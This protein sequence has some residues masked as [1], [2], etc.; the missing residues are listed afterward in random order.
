MRNIHML[1]SPPYFLFTSL[2]L[3]VVATFNDL[4]VI[5]DHGFHLQEPRSALSHRT[6]RVVRS[7]ILQFCVTIASHKPLPNLTNIQVQVSDLFIY[8]PYCL[9]WK[10]IS[11]PYCDL[12]AKIPPPTS[13][14]NLFTGQ[15]VLIFLPC[16]SF[17]FFFF[18]LVLP[19]PL[20]Y[21][22]HLFVFGKIKIL[23]SAF[24][25]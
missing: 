21:S 10:P 18:H 5:E 25:S 13:S 23:L 22:F 24:T 12:L 6:V 19:F 4:I 9:H 1:L 15:L 7:N 14:Q 20:T 3:W 17:F 8:C 11:E 2:A 16:Q